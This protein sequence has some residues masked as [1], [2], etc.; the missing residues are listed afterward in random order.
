MLK[1]D[2]IRPGT[3]FL[4]VKSQH[5]QMSW[6]YNDPYQITDFRANRNAVRDS[7]DQGAD[8]DGEEEHDD[9]VEEKQ[10]DEG[11]QG[12]IVNSIED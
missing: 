8:I 5:S 1:Q 4:S 11:E 10:Q 12:E 6:M 9:E 7:P 2:M 3:G